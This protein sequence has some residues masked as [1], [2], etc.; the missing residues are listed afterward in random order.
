MVI[1]QYIDVLVDFDQVIV[2]NFKD[3]VIYF[4]WVNVYGVFN[5]Y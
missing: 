1:E 4:N 3:L 5:N 2:L